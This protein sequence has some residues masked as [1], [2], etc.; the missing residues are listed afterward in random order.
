MAVPL[1]AKVLDLEGNEV[2]EKPL[3][4]AFNAPIRV[5]VVRRAV[6]ASLTR[7]LQPQGRDPMA[8]KRTTAESRGAGFGMARV[9]RIRRTGVAKFATMAVGGRSAHPPK[10]AKKI[11][12]KVNKKEKELAFLSALSATAVP[13]L[14]RARGHAIGDRP[15]PLVVSR[16]AEDIGK[17]AS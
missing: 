16:E 7:R 10:V 17:T 13:E 5:D 11:R 15:L 1:S 8:G 2:G 3:P 6:V 14:V 4:S 12:K 9:P